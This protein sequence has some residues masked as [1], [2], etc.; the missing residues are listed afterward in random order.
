MS[1]TCSARAT[2]WRR[3]SCRQRTCARRPIG[4]PSRTS[5]KPPA[6]ERPRSHTRAVR[7]AFGVF[8]GAACEAGRVVPHLPPRRPEADRAAVAR[9]LRQGAH[10]AGEVLVDQRLDPGE[11][12]N[13][14]RGEHSHRAARAPPPTAAH[15]GS[16]DARPR[17][18]CGVSTSRQ[19]P[20]ASA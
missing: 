6:L 7:A 18:T 5:A 20:S 10:A 4:H 2:R 15:T 14:R 13:R 16:A 17:V 9:V 11:H 19:V 3:T 12:P 1:R 8:A